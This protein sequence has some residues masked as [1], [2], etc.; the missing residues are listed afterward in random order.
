MPSV[1][2]P[3]SDFLALVG[4]E[5]SLE[6]LGDSIPMIGVGLDH[7]DGER[8]VLEVFP[9]RPDML[10]I[11]GFAR[12]FRGFVGLG[13]GLASYDAQDSG[14]RLIVE[15]SVDKVR[16][17]VSAG[18]VLDVTLDDYAIKSVMDIQEKLHL[19]HGRNRR[20]VAIGVHDL[21]RVKPPFTYKAVKPAD[22]SFVPLESTE[23]MNLTKI[24]ES[25]PKGRDYAGLLAGLDR[26]PLIVDSNGDV[27]SFPPIINGEL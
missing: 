12:A 19:T 5:Y 7:L 3:T 15:S 8:M 11:E 2:F 23:K 14:I 24:L 17:F 9:N 16:P 26:Y 13:S 22:V 1:E 6:E 25:H 4:R 20:K 27:L 10:S 21:D 18:V